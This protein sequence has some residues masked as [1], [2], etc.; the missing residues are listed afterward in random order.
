MS[1]DLNSLQADLPAAHE[2]EIHSV[3]PRTLYRNAGHLQDVHPDL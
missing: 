3:R 2:G 1:D